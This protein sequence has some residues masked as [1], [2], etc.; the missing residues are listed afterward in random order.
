MPTT[1][2]AANSVIACIDG[3]VHTHAV[4]DAAIWSA[5]QLNAPLGL[6]HAHDQVT[7]DDS[8]DYSGSIGFDSREHLLNELSQADADK[9]KLLREHGNLLLKEAKAYVKTRFSGEIFKLHR[10]ETLK[11][12]I[13]H[14]QDDV[15]LIILGQNSAKESESKKSIG[16]QLETT[17][18]ASHHPIYIVADQFK[19]PTSVLYAFD[20]RSTTKQGLKWLAN[21]PM[22]SKVHFHVVM[23]AENNIENE[24]AIRRAGAKL[25]QHGLKVTTKLLV[26]NPKTDLKQY[27]T[28]EAIDMMIIGAYGHSRLHEFFTGSTTKVLLEQNQGNLFLLRF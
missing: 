28:D 14:L 27:Q 26:G 6:L 7:C 15:Q 20:N 12:S 5:R 19:M 24:E 16:K 9:N 21:H 10:H 17:I 23:V 22:F 25:K 11:D 13:A 4:L 2:Y 1:T 3:S 18:R 8:H